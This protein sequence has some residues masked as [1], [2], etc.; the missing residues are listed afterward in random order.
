MALGGVPFGEQA[1]RLHR[2]RGEALHREALAAGV[3]RILERGVGVAL[4]ADNVMM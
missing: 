4:Y 3:G 2:H 1:A